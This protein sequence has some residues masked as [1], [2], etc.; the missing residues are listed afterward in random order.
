[1]E[2]CDRGKLAEPASI[3]GQRENAEWDR[4]TDADKIRLRPL[5][6]EFKK[7]CQLFLDAN[8]ESW[9]SFLDMCVVALAY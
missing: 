3:V 1:M 8:N 7:R 4:Q 6:F 9:R 5:T 2:P